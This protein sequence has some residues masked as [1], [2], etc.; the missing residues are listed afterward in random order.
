MLVSVL[1]FSPLPLWLPLLGSSSASDIIKNS[2]IIEMVQTSTERLNWFGMQLSFSLLVNL[3]ELIWPPGAMTLSGLRGK[4]CCDGLVM[5]SMGRE[6]REHWYVCQIFGIA[7]L[8]GFGNP[9]W[10]NVLIFEWMECRL[11]PETEGIRWSVWWYKGWYESS[12]IKLD[13]FW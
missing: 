9:F 12:A 2:N 4:K 10:A 13:A 7:R 3:S 5:N 1:P 6:V 11:R 8:D